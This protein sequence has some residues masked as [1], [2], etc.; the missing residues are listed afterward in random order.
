M[1]ETNFKQT[2][3]GLI[4]NDW[5]VKPMGELYTIRSSKR[6]FQFQWTSQG[7][8]FYR[9]REIV[10]LNNREKF[11]SPLF[12]SL[13][14]YNQLKDTYGVPQ[15]NDILVTGVGTL[16]IPYL[17]SDNTPFYFKDGNIIWL[18]YLG[19]SDS[20]FIQYCYKSSI[21]L[22]QVNGD[23][24]GST[25]GTYT[26]Q[27]ARKTLVPCPKLEEQIKIGEI[28]TDIDSL[29]FDLQKLIVKKRSIKAGAMS[30]LL[31]GKRRL[32]GFSEPWETNELDQIGNIFP[33]NSLSWDC[34]TSEGTV[35]NIHYGQIL[36]K[37]GAV[38][39]VSKTSLPYI[40]SNY[41]PRFLKSN[42][43]KDGDVIFAD[44]AE[45]DT[46]GKAV[47]L[48]NIED[49]I[50]V[51]GLHT[52]WFRPT[53]KFAPKFLGYALNEFDFHSQIPPLSTGTKV[54]SI[55]KPNLL[56]LVLSYP[57]DIKEQ[58]AIAKILTDMDD[59]IESLEKKLAKYEQVKQGMMSELLTGKIRLI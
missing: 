33:N 39:D 54:S 53:I 15:I 3:V 27:R 50:V 11:S 9:A 25:V 59:E 45:D 23:G 49:A 6:V 48:T 32:P 21:L 28:L 19:I 13:E 26:I 16:G 35:A 58:E 34:L 37:F 40:K 47:E 43:A 52:F 20:T 8:P 46:V 42:I 14:L 7:V 17:I 2:E 38:V 44:T 29:I 41:E 22:N 51:S 55:S 4:P 36:T 24:V 31:T 12:I 30:C 56:K 1:R 5:D 57:T 18:Q 10:S